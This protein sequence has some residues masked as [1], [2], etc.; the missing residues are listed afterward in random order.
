M[1]TLHCCS[2]KILLWC[3]AY[4]MLACTKHLL[5]VRGGK[6]GPYQRGERGKKIRNCGKKYFERS[7]IM[8]FKV[9]QA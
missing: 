4:G 3:V 8:V 9:G 1:L 2:M 5:L 7:S 6:K